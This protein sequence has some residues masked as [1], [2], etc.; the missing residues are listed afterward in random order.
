MSNAQAG[1]RTYIGLRYVPIIKGVWDNSQEYEQLCIVVYQGNSYTS[2]KPVP[3][4]VDILNDEYWVCTGNYNV[5]IANLQNEVEV[6]VRQILD[7]ATDFETFK[8]EMVALYDNFV[9]DADG[10]V[11]AQVEEYERIIGEQ[12]ESFQNYVMNAL[13]QFREE[14]TEFTDETNQRIDDFISSSNERIDNKFTTYQNTMNSQYNDFVNTTGQAITTLQADVDNMVLNAGN[15][16]SSSAEIVQARQNRTK[17][18]PYDTL[19]DSINGLFD[20]GLFYHKLTVSEYSDDINFNNWVTIGVYTSSVGR[21][22]NSPFGTINNQGFTM[23]VT[24]DNYRVVNQNLNITYNGKVY[25]FKRYRL[26]STWSE[27]TEFVTD[28]NTMIYTTGEHEL[29]SEPY[30]YDFNSFEPNTCY[31]M[32]GFTVGTRPLN[33]PSTLS[34]GTPYTIMTFG[35]DNDNKY[36]LCYSGTSN[37]CFIR[38]RINGVW[39]NWDYL[40]TK[41]DLDSLYATISGGFVKGS[42][43]ATSPETLEQLNARTFENLSINFIRL[44]NNLFPD[45]GLTGDSLFYIFNTANYQ[46]FIGTDGSLYYR[47]KTGDTWGEIVA[48]YDTSDYQEIGDYSSGISVA[49]FNNIDFDENKIGRVKFSE[50]IFGDTVP[51]SNDQKCY[52]FTTTSHGVTYQTLVSITGRTI[53]RT[54]TSDVWSAFVSPYY[55]KAEVNALI[56]T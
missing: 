53:A 47:T 30:Q 49:D 19:Q 7:Y 40:T 24:T 2:K 50:D 51:D 33:S 14:M 35:A 29:D 43:V 1:F 48:S 52:V 26:G 42:N 9:V 22:I 34:S 12:Y 5:Q 11:K 18:T 54:K 6:A 4:G 17:T 56:N 13:N 20:N 38:I 3:I 36:Q 28:E 8:N 44:F 31:F 25:N 15:P 23:I 10:E 45:R 37:R 16:E 32:G 41:D 27:W 21:L 55:T 46:T 39:T